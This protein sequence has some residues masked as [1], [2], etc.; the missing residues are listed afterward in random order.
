[1]GLDQKLRTWDGH[2]VEN[3]EKQYDMPTT[4]EELLVVIWGFKGRFM[5]PHM[6]SSPGL[7]KIIVP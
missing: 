7:L 1:M 5:N 2:G 4:W 3:R 6:F